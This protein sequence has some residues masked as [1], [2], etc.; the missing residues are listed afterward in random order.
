M[1]AMAIAAVSFGVV[2]P[3]SWGGEGRTEQFGDCT[4]TTTIGGRVAETTAKCTSRHRYTAVTVFTMLDN[5]EW[6]GEGTAT[7]TN[8][9]GTGDWF[10]RS[11][12]GMSRTL[13][14]LWQAVAAYKI[15]GVGAFTASSGSPVY[16]CY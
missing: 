9:F 6:G 16:R 7:F 8:S 10:V 2:A 1:I 5:R 15:A 3:A 12:G 13:C 4:V 14:G 11:G